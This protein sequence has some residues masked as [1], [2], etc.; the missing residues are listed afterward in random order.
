LLRHLLVG[1]VI[2]TPREDGAVDF[3]GEASIGPLLAGTLLADTA[4]WSKALVSPRGHQALGVFGH[5]ASRD[6][7]GPRRWPGGAP[8]DRLQAKNLE[9]PRAGIPRTAFVPGSRR[10]NTRSMTRRSTGS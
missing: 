2:F 4:S 6:R 8:R 1:R 7:Y 5:S 10:T 9:K 3:R